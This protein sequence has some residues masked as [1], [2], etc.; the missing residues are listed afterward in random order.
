MRTLT[1]QLWQ[2]M[3]REWTLQIR[4]KKSWVNSLLFFAMIL[5]LFA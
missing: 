3:R 4:Q 2:Q 5:L 1:Q